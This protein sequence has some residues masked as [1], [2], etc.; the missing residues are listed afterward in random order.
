MALSDSGGSTDLYGKLGQ[1]DSPFTVLLSGYPLLARD[2]SHGIVEIQLQVRHEDEGTVECDDHVISLNWR[3]G[4][5]GERMTIEN[6][7]FLLGSPA[8]R[9]S[10]D[11]STNASTRSSFSG[12]VGWWTIDGPRGPRVVPALAP[13]LEPSPFYVPDVFIQF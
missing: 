12:R 10:S 5:L 11:G 7:V 6:S 2:W 9:S 4:E 1:G 8:P 13:A 3:D